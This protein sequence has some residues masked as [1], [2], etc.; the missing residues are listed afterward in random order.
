MAANEAY[1]LWQW[2]TGRTIGAFLGL[3]PTQ[4]SSGQSRSL[5]GITKTGNARRCWSRRRGITEDP[6]GP[7]PICI[8][9]AERRALIGRCFA[10]TQINRKWYGDG[11]EIVTDE[12]KLFL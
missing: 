9:D 11:T 6:P 12:G 1:A 7:R 4:Y 8:G 10:A 5:G 2:L 3:V